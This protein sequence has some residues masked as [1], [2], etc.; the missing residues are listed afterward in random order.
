MSYT[1][2]YLKEGRLQWADHCAD[3]LDRAKDM[4]MAA[5]SDDASLRAEVRDEQG[6]LLFQY[7]PA[8]QSA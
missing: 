4:A 6:N 2:D 8:I 1:I 7:P 5:V 3:T